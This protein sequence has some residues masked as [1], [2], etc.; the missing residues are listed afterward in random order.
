MSVI[1][2][3]DLKNKPN[4]ESETVF[5]KRV[6]TMGYPQSIIDDIHNLKKVPPHATVQM[7]ADIKLKIVHANYRVATFLISLADGGK[8]HCDFNQPKHADEFQFEV[9]KLVQ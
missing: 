2:V 6:T 5:L 1:T 4:F 3:Q 9:D 7:T 8:V